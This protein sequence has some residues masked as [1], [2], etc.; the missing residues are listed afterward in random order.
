MPVLKQHHNKHKGAVDHT[1]KLPLLAGEL[2]ALK[3][4]AFKRKESLRT[5]VTNAAIREIKTKGK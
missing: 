1:I 5:F 3:S 2:K 4:A